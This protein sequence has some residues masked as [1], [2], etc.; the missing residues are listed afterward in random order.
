MHCMHVFSTCEGLHIMYIRACFQCTVLMLKEMKSWEK[1]SP[2][3][4]AHLYLNAAL[5]YSF[6]VLSKFL[7]SCS[8]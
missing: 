4:M 3:L 6:F 5:I 7:L 1:I 8:A 2:S